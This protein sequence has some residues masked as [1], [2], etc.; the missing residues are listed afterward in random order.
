MTKLLVPAV[1]LALWL[2]V[3]SAL[4][5]GSSGSTNIAD[6]STTPVNF[7]SVVQGQTGPSVTFTVRNDG[8]QILNLSGL[9]VP[10]G[11]T[12]TDGLV[13]QPIT[14]LIRRMAL[15]GQPGQP[16]PD[17]PHASGVGIASPRSTM[18]A[19]VPTTLVDWPPNERDGFVFR[20]RNT[21]AAYVV[22]T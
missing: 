17:V 7:G 21:V 22:S 19:G 5:Q 11:Y 14:A 3:P 13:S 12:I 1:L 20:P 15:S 10:A 2:V 8:G 4:A 6:N 16:A 18:R 9:S